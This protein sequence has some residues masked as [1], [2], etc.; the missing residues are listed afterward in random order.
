MQF[1][2]WLNTNVVHKKNNNVPL[3]TADLAGAFYYT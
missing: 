1:E 3:H 2:I